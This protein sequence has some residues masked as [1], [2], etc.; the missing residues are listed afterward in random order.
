VLRGHYDLALLAPSWDHRCESITAAD[1][2]IGTCIILRFS[3]K[4][5][6][7]YQEKH[8]K[9]IDEFLARQSE[10]VVP[11][12]GD[13]VN[14][15]E[16]WDDLWETAL[17]ITRN[18]DAPLRI[19]V[20]LS[21]C[22][23]YYSLGFIAGMLQYGLAHTIAVFYAEGKYN[24]EAGPHPIDYPF[25]MGQWN[26]TA[27]P[28]LRG[29]PDPLKRRSY[30]VS[31]GFEGVKTARVLSREDPDRVGVL[32]PDPGVQPGY[33]EETWNRN[34]EIIAQYRIADESIVR[35]P[36]GDAIA[37][38]KALSTA[39]LEHSSKESTYY[40]CCG[41]KPHALGLALRAIC[42]GSSTVMYNLPERH[43]FM[44]V[45]PSGVFW[46]YD[47]VDVTTPTVGSD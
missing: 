37:A 45:S 5:E 28:F 36:A 32:F 34:K 17:R 41:T 33:V 44:E 23:R 14:L 22:P 11:V 3:T 16:I 1:I 2:T 6:F 15:P 10:T 13:A 47:L 40:L 38:W 18:A 12:K 39:K 9:T 21:T 29:S 4:D 20:D 43:S 27:I 25:T 26:A 42:I 7:G 8:E 30:I 19:L 35:A 46:S 31:V 24:N